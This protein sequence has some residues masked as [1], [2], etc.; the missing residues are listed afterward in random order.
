[1]K[2]PLVLLPG[3]LCDDAVWQPQTLALADIADITIA[4]HG[5]LD[6]LGAMAEAV[7][8]RA[9]A[10]FAVAGHS[11][12]GRVAFEVIRRAPERVTA[13][14]ILDS[15]FAPLAQ[16]AAGE[17][18]IAGRQRLVAL[19]RNAG[20]R[21]MGQDW[22][23][24]MVHPSRLA[25][26]VLVNSILDMIE[27]K[28]PDHFEAQVRALL[29][30]PDARPL[31]PRI[32]CPALVLCGREDSWSPLAQHVE[33]AELIPASR[34]IALAECGHMSTLEKPAEVSAAMREWLRPGLLAG[35]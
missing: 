16:G 4:D 28:T 15:A 20:M 25:D 24:A 6:S 35:N 31:L 8:A 10:R 21:V 22:L 27:R 11:M 23:Q 9:P 34:L 2:L 13:L 12:G 33:M 30:R 29:G 19:A 5:L 1:M 17:R 26:R 14:A 18:E 3:L 7:L 32:A